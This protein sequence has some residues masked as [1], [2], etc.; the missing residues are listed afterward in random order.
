MVCAAD[1]EAVESVHRP[2][3]EFVPGQVLVKYK[4]VTRV[5]TAAYYQRAYKIAT[6]DSFNMIGVDLL[7]LPGAM[8]VEKAIEMF[9]N[10]PNVM[11]VEPNYYRYV[12]GTP[13]DPLF[14]QLWGMKKIRAPQAWDTTI[15]ST[16]V[17]IA[18]IDSGVHWTHP[19]LKANMWQ[20]PGET[21]GN[22]ID[23]DMNGYVDD[24][25]GWDFAFNDNNP[26][27][28]NG[29]GTHVAGTAAA[30][31]NNSIGVTGLS[32]RAKIMALRFIDAGGTGSTSDAIKAIL[33]ANRNGAHIQNLSWGG[34]G[35]S[36]ALKDAIDASAAVIVAAAG[37]GG[38]DGIGDNNDLF[39]HYPSSYASSNLIAVAAI[40]QNDNLPSFS[41]FGLVSVDVTAP[42]VGILST[43]SP[44][45]TGNYGKKT[46]T[47]MAAP[48]VAGLAGLIVANRGGLS[49]SSENSITAASD[50]IQI[51]NSTVDP[52]ASLTGRIATGGRVNA[53]EAVKSADD[54]GGGCFIATAAFGSI[55]EPHVHI[56]QQFRDRYL[57]TNRVGLAFVKQ[58]Y[59]YSPPLADI[60]QSH[61]SLKWATRLVLLPVVGLSWLAITFGLIASLSMIGLLTLLVAA[62][63]LKVKNNR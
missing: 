19:D 61:E 63:W 4:P 29:H 43:H 53:F 27:D 36:R 52:I 13:N 51:I 12:T 50:V 3:G 21:P 20:N 6:I 44:A 16:G 40:D 46:G 26:N 37:N 18:V 5:E 8:G 54:D 38:A 62:V 35:F 45:N 33:Y 42:G 55:F 47:S 60:I 9:K 22:S 10:D 1:S 32:Q 25:V 59:T 48:H 49:V 28:G 41:N 2:S 39:P 15:G 17:V 24:I 58:Y 7:K 23:D 31:G 34:G 14:S 11:F 30:V 56:L 57:Q